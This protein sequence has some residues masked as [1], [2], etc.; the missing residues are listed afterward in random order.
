MVSHWC[1]LRAHGCGCN[2]YQIQR[3]VSKISGPIRRS[4]GEG[5][6][7]LDRAGRSQSI[8]VSWAETADCHPLAVTA[9]RQNTPRSG[10][11]LLVTELIF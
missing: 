3:Y 9:F 7:L 6:P 4:L 8:S 5:G 11:P 2:P 10:Y 1:T